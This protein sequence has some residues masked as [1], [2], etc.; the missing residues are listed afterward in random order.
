ML[1][2]CDVLKTTMLPN[3]DSSE[4]NPCA[5]VMD[6][7]QNESD[8]RGYEAEVGNTAASTPLRLSSRELFREG[9]T[10][11]IEHEEQIYWLRLTRGNKL[12]L[13]K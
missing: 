8:A 10:V 4:N 3:Y 5:T 12:I 6:G 13:T 9:N 2:N 1:P 11:C 7:A